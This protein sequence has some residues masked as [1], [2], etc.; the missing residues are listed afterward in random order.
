MSSQATTDIF[1]E[2]VGMSIG[3]SVIMILLGMLAIFLPL[4]TG[5]GVSIMVGWLMVLGGL[6]Y[7][8]HAFS[9]QG[10]GSFIW[11]ML[12][13]IFYVVGGGYLA[14][15]PGLALAS[16]TL[17]M[18]AIFFVEGIME[19]VLFAQFYSMS[20]SG[21]FLFDGVVTM[22][23]AYLIWQPWPASSGWAIGTLLGI[24]LIVS[25]LTRMMYSIEARKAIH[26]TA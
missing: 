10:A 1:K 14:F 9:A 11:R 16:L 23:L 13:G 4:A 18:A 19:I 22:I 26:A 5:I 6:T 12:V 25:G 20:G 2:A 15:H 21:W 8:A 7:I 3:W 17:V 24:N